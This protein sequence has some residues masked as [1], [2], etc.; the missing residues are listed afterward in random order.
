MPRRFHIVA[1]FYASDLLH[2]Y[3]HLGGFDQKLIVS[4]VTS[5][6]HLAVLFLFAARRHPADKYSKQRTIVFSGKWPRS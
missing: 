3:V 6:F 4:I 5:M 2:G 1:I